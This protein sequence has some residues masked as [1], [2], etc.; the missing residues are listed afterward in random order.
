[1]IS[2]VWREIE[3]SHVMSCFTNLGAQAAPGLRRRSCKYS[4]YLAGRDDL[5]LLTEPDRDRSISPEVTFALA[6]VGAPGRDDSSL[7]RLLIS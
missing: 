4:K 6:Q 1:M 2:R 7:L 3:L 5:L